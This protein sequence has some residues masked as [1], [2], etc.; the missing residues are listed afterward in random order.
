[1][2][3]GGNQPTGGS[4]DPF[5]IIGGG[6][7]GKERDPVCGMWVDPE[8]AAGRLDHEGKTYYFC[9]PSCQSRFRSD[10][11]RYLRPEAEPE[12]MEVA[13]EPGVIPG[14]TEYICPMDPE[15]LQDHPGAC[16]VCGMALEPRVAQLEETEN[17]ELIDMKR[18]LRVS[19]LLTLPL[20]A[21]AMAEMLT[22]AS[23]DAL[24]PGR[25]SVWLQLL[26]ATPVVLW[27]G[28]PF[29]QR[30]YKSLVSRKLNMFTLISLGTG[31]A[32]VYSVLAALVP[33]IFPA[34]FH[35]P[36]G[37]PAPYFEAAAAII[38]LVLLGQVLELKARGRT[39]AAIKA[40]LGLAPKTARLVLADG[41]EAD[42]PL[43]AV[44]VGN[45]LRVR[46]GEK[47]PVDGVVSDGLSSVDESMVTG[48]PV[49]VE[50][51]PGDGVTGGTVNGAG[52]FVMRAERVGSDTLLAQIVRI[53]SEAQRSRA[54]IQRVA[55]T[56][57]SY[58]VPAVGMIAAVTFVIWAVAGPPP[59][60]AYALVNAVAVLII[61][62][63]CA[64][65][66]ATPM[67]IMVG[68]GRGAAAGILIKKA[69]VLET[70]ERI[71]TLVFDKTGTLTEGKPRLAA[72]LPLQPWSEDELLRLAA[73]V[74]RGSEHP[75][76]DAIH[77]AARERGLQLSA[78]G[79]FAA[80]PGKGV[81][82]VV[83]G[84]EVAVGNPALLAAGMPGPSR[85]L[86]ERAEDLRQKGQTTV[87][88]II[89]GELAGLLSAEDPLKQT[90][91]QAVDDL[92]RSGLELVMVTGDSQTTA[93]NVARRLRIDRVVAGV[94]PQQKGEIVRGL[95]AG[96]QV[97]A[98]AGDGINDAPA[99]AQADVGIAMGTGSDIAIHS[100]GITLLRGDLRGIARAR[101]L[102]AATMRNIRQ[103]LLFAFLYNALCIPVAAGVLYPLFGLLLSPMIAAAAMTFSSVS[104]I[105]NALRLRRVP[106]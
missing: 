14:G 26:L 10:P 17:P 21:L 65:G 101:R 84:R 16:P 83:E 1:M 93:E 44:R 63:P 106:L 56:V 28:L 91:A 38:T 99:L 61:A 78:A 40:L 32:Y 90:T 82:G 15:V 79:S 8:R 74:E 87:F 75:L 67:S 81:R 98:M 60:L 66:L 48:E 46:P 102:S 20:L 22:G 104:V 80:L 68:T 62:C 58:F 37:G 64:L 31:T 13:A 2:S 97:V 29:F 72:A 88:V 76:A 3:G 53:V 6:V 59:R 77:S 105:S 95:Q 19:L 41:N 33:D 89:D 69:E 12:P 5:V 39:S 73:S 27:G 9:N 47:V 49:P 7:S 51:R 43:S 18:R 50:K 54:P 35:Q 86:L 42:V 52:S 57:A 70:L 23:L 92:H 96:G 55:D 11:D 45:R 25:S 100:A 4:R 30:G 34:S 85:A 94:L 24:L 36:G 103:N 71:N